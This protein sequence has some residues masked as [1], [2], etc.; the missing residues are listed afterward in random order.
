M[1]IMGV[2]KLWSAPKGGM[3]GMGDALGTLW[4]RGIENLKTAV[5]VAPASIA[6]MHTRTHMT[7]PKPA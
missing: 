3:E 6:M 7:S 5:N 4:D 2:L 1:Y